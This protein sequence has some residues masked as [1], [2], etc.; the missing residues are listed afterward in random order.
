MSQ[1]LYR[2]YRPQTFA[3]VIGQEVVSTIIKN[4]VASGRIS[5]AYLF[6][7]P[8]G[9]GKTTVARILAKAVNCLSPRNG[10]PDTTCVNCELLKQGRFLDLFEIDAAS[11]TGV[12]NVREIIDHVKFPPGVGRYK[13]FIIDEVHMLSKAA[14]NALL[15]TLEEPPAHVI[16][17]L[18][19]TEIQKV[20]ATIISRSQRF[21]F[22]QISLKDIVGLLDKVTHDL[23]VTFPKEAKMLI[24]RTAS[25]SLRDALSIL[26][27]LIATGESTI[28][29][30]QVEEILGVTR[31]ESSQK[32]L[33]FLVKGQATK[34]AEFIK[35]LVFEGRDLV[36]FLKNFLEYLRLVLLVKMG[37]QSTHDLG[38]TE[39]QGSELEHEA[40]SLSGAKLSE[41]I[42]K[43]LE[44]Y[45]EA[46]QSPIPELPVLIQVY[47]FKTDDE[48]PKKNLAKGPPI[49]RAE[50]G[51]DLGMIIDRWAQVLSRIRDYN[52][53]LLSSLRL[54]RIVD[55]SGL[56][57]TL[58]FPYNF[59]KETIEARKNKIVV[60]QVLEDVYSRPLKIKIFLERELDHDPKTES[61]DLLSEAMKILGNSE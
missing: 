17:I 60:E 51:L 45:R 39:E 32:F 59:H 19:T 16:F 23:K 2:K 31:V 34:A 61:H 54:G 57:L 48:S 47:S 13:V 40:R 33:E 37:A 18:A 15:K 4:A 29:L 49:E 30:D 20:P 44:S 3:E 53:S 46:K 38:L 12:D 52:H 1:V 10:E 58:A 35:R 11:Y 22:R 6:C 26:D 42:K 7:G 14:F 27:Q 25:G 28:T 5:H 41:I 21:D 56:D 55:L 8:R 9:V 43:F 50:V 24:A 36:L